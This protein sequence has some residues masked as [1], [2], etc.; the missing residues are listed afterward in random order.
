MRSTTI[1]SLIVL[2]A[3][4]PDQVQ[5]WS[6]DVLRRRDLIQLVATSCSS[7][8]AA[9]LLG[10]G[11]NVPAWAEDSTSI[12]RS[13]D[14][15]VSKDQ[16]VLVLGANGQTGRECVRLAMAQGRPCLASSR[17]GIIEGLDLSTNPP[18]QPSRMVLTATAAIDVTNYESIETAVRGKNIGAMIFA[19][20]AGTGRND[21]FPVDRDGVIYAAQ[22][23]I[24]NRIPRLVIVS[25]GSVTRPDTAVYQLLNLVGNGIMEAKIQGE[26]AVKKLYATPEAMQQGL[27]YTILRPGGLTAPILEPRGA[28]FMELNQGDT[29]SGRLSRTDVAALCL[30][31]LDS[32]ETFDTTF[33]CYEKETAKPLESVGL[34]NIL[35]LSNP[36]PVQYG[37]ERRGDTYEALFRELQRD[38]GHMM[39][40]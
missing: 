8:A 11:V 19:A 34:S 18:P 24:A 2:I 3:N 10:G 39:A 38:P 21:P 9:T 22:C 25:S 29:K 13:S 40:L 30:E 32:P 6:A 14:L 27:G 35:R 16:T 31:A 12:Q 36:T 15:I 37:L 26:D 7:V 4:L 23:C 20:S 17:N 5:S 28:P 1:L 33:E